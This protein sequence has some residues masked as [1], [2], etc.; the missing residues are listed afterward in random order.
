MSKHYT[1]DELYIL[2]IDNIKDIK[3][4]LKIKSNFKTKDKLIKLILEE[5]QQPGTHTSDK[6]VT[7]KTRTVKAVNYDTSILKKLVKKKR[8]LK[9]V[10]Q[11]QDDNTK[12]IHKSTL[13]FIDKLHNTLY[14]YENIVDREAMNDIIMLFMIKFINENR[15]KFNILDSSSYT[16]PEAFNIFIKNNNDIFDKFLK[17]EINNN[18]DK[19][20]RPTIKENTDF[21]TSLGEVLGYHK[22]LKHIFKVANFLNAKQYD[23]IVKLMELFNDIKLEFNNVEDLMGEIYEYFINKYAKGKSKLGQFFTPRCLMKCILEIYSDKF[24]NI[25]NDISIYDPCMGTAG[26]LVYMYNFIKANNSNININV[27]GNEVESSTFKYSNINIMNSIENFNSELLYNEDSIGYI[28][29]FK[30]D[31]IFT[32][33]PFGTNSKSDVGTGK[34]KTSYLKSSFKKNTNDVYNKMD[35]NDIYTL[36][37]KNMP[38]Q[39]LEACIWKLNDGG[40]CS[41]VLPYGELFFSDRCSQARL[42]FMKVIDIQSII[43]VPSG[44]FTHTG[45]KTCVVSFVKSSSGT[46]N[47]QFMEVNKECNEVT[48]LITITKDDIMKETNN[49]WYLQDYINDDYIE[50][51]KKKINCKWIEFGELFTLEEGTCQ[52]SKVEEDAHSDIVL[53]NWSLY[54][55]YKKI[56]N[57]K[58]DGNNLFISHKLPNGNDI[59]Y[60]VIKYYTGKCDIVNLMSRVVIKDE[61]KNKINLKY[62][63]YYLLDMKTHIEDNYQKGSCNKSLDIKNFNRLLVPIPTIETQNKLTNY[64]DNLHSLLNTNIEYKSKTEQVRKDLFES[65]VWGQCLYNKDLEEKYLGEVCEFQNGSPLNK[66][67]FI[68]GNYLVIGSGKTPIGNHNTYNINENTIICATSGNAGLISIYNNKCW[69]TDAIAIIPNNELVNK[70]LY[71]YLKNIEINIQNTAR[72]I[73]QQHVNENIL[74]K[75]KIPIPPLDKQK[76]VVDMME[77][78][79]NKI[80]RHIDDINWCKEKTTNQFFTLLGQLNGFDR[81]KLFNLDSSFEDKSE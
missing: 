55:K 58:Y 9:G 40:F 37:D 26:F 7:K 80:S 16:E 44:V 57:Y 43:L 62:I 18:Y 23:T 78:M 69:I 56:K 63:Y 24:T 10:M 41:I 21:I 11:I 39:V 22:T 71:Y 28:R 75:F 64:F 59:G 68:I 13:A 70:Y 27:Y 5:Q 12:D 76:E 25:S 35:F 45:I 8:S 49:S 33:P 29:D 66:S 67:K 72:G 61:Y 2:N 50:N 73:G 17:F 65:F 42:H 3:K 47:I 74:S 20:I 48:E 4:S 1:L 31:Y 14:T 38:I 79:E 36:D 60:L 77:V 81:T 54:N 15:E 32:N 19:E 53:I 30:V 46:K 34:T 51:I 52:S 6:T